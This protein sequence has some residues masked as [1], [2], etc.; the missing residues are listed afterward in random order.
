VRVVLDTNVLVSACWKPDGLEAQTVTLAVLGAFT[1]CASTQILAEYREV[2]FRD[3]FAPL[4]GR[5]TLLLAALEPRLLMLQAATQVHATRDEDDH[6]FID[7]AAA[8]R[9]DYL[10]TG[11]LKDFPAQWGHTR[12]V[13]AR[14]FLAELGTVK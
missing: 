9:A 13:N 11:N 2:L 4:R 5:A 12:A 14:Q 8:A 10:V 7:C 3:K 6:C 1:A